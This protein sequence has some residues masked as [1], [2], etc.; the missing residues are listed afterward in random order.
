MGGQARQ[1]KDAFQGFATAMLMGVSAIF[2]ILALQFGSFLN[3][4]TIMF[5]LPLSIIEAFLG[6][7]VFGKDLGMMA[8][9]GIIMLMGIVTKNAILIVDFILTMRGRGYERNDAVLRSSQVRLRPILMTAAAMILGML[10]IAL[11]IGAGSEFRSP[12]AVVV[13]GGLLTS[14]LLTLVVVPVAYTLLDDFKLL[15]IRILRIKKAPEEVV[16]PSVEPM[17]IPVFVD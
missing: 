9:I 17:G 14:T 4:L 16:A 7:L 3:P 2:F 6:L 1:Q 5:S 11:G 8:L 13:I 15:F 12:M 10:P